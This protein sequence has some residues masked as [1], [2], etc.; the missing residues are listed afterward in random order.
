MA[1]ASRRRIE[2]SSRAARNRSPRRATPP[3][4]RPRVEALECRTVPSGLFSDPIVT[5][6]GARTAIAAGRFVNGDPRLDVVAL[7]SPLN[8]DIAINL[9]ASDGHGGLTSLGSPIDT[10]FPGFALFAVAGDFNGDGNLDLAFMEHMSSSPFTSQL[11]L[12]LGDGNGSF[13]QAPVFPFVDNQATGAIM[14]AN[15][16]GHPDLVIAG[17]PDVTVLLNDGAANFTSQSFRGGV[18]SPDGLAAGLLNNDSNSDLAVLGVY[19]AVSIFLGDGQGAFPGG[20]SGPYGTFAV[21]GGLNALHTGN[22]DGDNHLDV[23]VAGGVSGQAYVT[24]LKGDGTGAFVQQPAT[25]LGSSGGVTDS[26]V[27]DF[28]N[29]NKADL[30][31]TISDGTT[32]VVLGDGKDGFTDGGSTTAHVAGQ[33][34]GYPS[35]LAGDFNNDSKPDVVLVDSNGNLDVLLNQTPTPRVNT[36][37]TL[38][39]FANPSVFG[40]PVTFTAAVQWTGSGTPSGTVTFKD[41]MNTLGT[42]QLDGNGQTSFTAISPLGLGSNHAITAIYSGDSN[43][44]GSTSSLAQTVRAAQRFTWSG[45]GNTPDW[46]DNGNW[47]GGVAPAPG[48]MLVFPETAAQRTNV[49][50][51]PAGSNFVSLT[52][53]GNS[54]SSGLGYVVSGNAISIGSGGLID[55]ATATTGFALDNLDCD[56]VGAGPNLTVA[57]YN[58]AIVRIRGRVH[59]DARLV[60]TGTGELLLAGLNDYTNTTLIQQGNLVIANSFALGSTTSGTV[61]GRFGHLYILANVGTVLEPLTFLPAPAGSVGLFNVGGTNDWSGPIWLQSGPTSL[62][63]TGQLTLSGVVMGA[64]GL[65]VTSLGGAYNGRLVLPASNTFSGLLDIAAGTVDL[66]NSSGAGKLGVGVRKGGTLQIEGGINVPYN[67]ALAG[68][69]LESLDDG[70]VWS[71]RIVPL[72]GFTSMIQTDTG[73]L[74]VPGSIAPVQF[75]GAVGNLTKT[76]EAELRLTGK[77]DSYLGSIEIDAGTVVVAGKSSLPA[78]AA[79]I[80]VLDGATLAFATDYVTTVGLTIA[81]AGVDNL[82][83]LRLE[84]NNVHVT[85]QGGMTLAKS[86]YVG[87]DSGSK[88][89][90]NTKPITGDD[91]ATLAKVGPGTLTL[92]GADKYA[93]PTDIL[94]GV[95]VVQDSL[96]LGP[97]GSAGTSVYQGATLE[98]TFLAKSLTIGEDLV[99]DGRSA[100]VPALRNS[101]G[102]DVLNGNLTLLSTSRISVTAGSL[103]VDS[104]LDGMP[105]AGLIKSG[106]GFLVLRG[107][108]SHTGATIVEAGS[109]AVR[110]DHTSSTFEVRSSAAAILDPGATTGSLDVLGGLVNLYVQSSPGF[111]APAVTDLTLSG[112]SVFEYHNPKPGFVPPLPLVASGS[113]TLGGSLNLQFTTQNAP[114]VSAP[115]FTLIHKAS[116]GAIIGMFSNVAAD[117]TLTLGTMTFKVSI[118]N[119][120]ADLMVKRLS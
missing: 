3:R 103:L 113:V 23:V 102:G 51:Y 97:V 107:A 33:H 40:Q 100:L 61:V 25:Y 26:L 114:A 115:P 120:G 28:D 31:V 17:D 117:G 116:A 95:V 16:N 108:D 68:G 104:A 71:G 89:T 58:N 32:R 111:V 27:A 101:G 65:I 72:P 84:G 37:V 109:L 87:V 69:T 91:T 106:P 52:F 46:I 63:V 57:S 5:P 76:G 43:F 47:V 18:Y 92:A 14:S 53:V 112:A 93:G 44:K 60:K 81:G 105:G 64:G 50:D 48:D 49:N 8:Q 54:A 55:K 20:A 90:V 35:L 67:L 98:M 39:S 36:S 21:A 9:F 62:A 13:A 45:L 78:S 7:N 6:F 94:D 79:G 83:A 59:G 30:F 38:Q 75:F 12:W 15:L 110:G 96:A 119:G 80:N 42:G 10:G 24:I 74:V 1:L 11:D 77:D 34:G 19:G 85:L 41:G 82:G 99:L 70:N 66:R 22:F 2:S 86:A 29:D 73:S 118:E 88:L 4:C 56:I